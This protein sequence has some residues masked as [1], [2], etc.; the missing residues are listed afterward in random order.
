MGGIDQY[1][2]LMLHMNGA[3]GSTTIVDEKGHSFSYNLGGSLST[4]NPKFAPTCAVNGGSS[5]SLIN[6]ADGGTPYADLAIGT[7]DFTIDLWFLTTTTAATP[8][9]FDFRPPG[10]AGAYPTLYMSGNVL[11]Y[12][13]V[14]AD[15][16]I[17][18]TAIAINTWHHAALTRSGTNTKLWLNGA[19]E[20]L[21]FAA[22]STS[23]LNNISLRPIFMNDSVVSANP[24]QGQIDEVRISIG[25]ARWNA[26]FTPPNLPYSRSAGGFWI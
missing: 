5:S 8:F 24:L 21:T 15:R 11:H 9:L 7:A 6:A 19:Q 13:T 14:S 4:T 23:Y 2:K 18:A 26:A 17:G 12:Q 16:I 20:G 22:D 3:N 1:T 10:G 25:I